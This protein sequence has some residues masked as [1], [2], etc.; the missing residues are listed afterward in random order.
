LVAS[1]A[2]VDSY[3]VSNG[4]ISTTDELVLAY[5]SR[6]RIRRGMQSTGCGGRFV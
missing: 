3:Q 4:R 2:D 6:A 5:M 1:S